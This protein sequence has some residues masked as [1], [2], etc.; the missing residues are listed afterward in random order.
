MK[1]VGARGSGKFKKISWEEA[2]RQTVNILEPIRKNYP[3]KLAFFTGRDQLDRLQGG[4]RN[5]WNTELCRPRR[6]LL[7]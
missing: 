5:N 3:E 7:G 4:G 2:L 1:R 6:F